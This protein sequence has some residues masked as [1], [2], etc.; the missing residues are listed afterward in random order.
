MSEARVIEQVERRFREAIQ[1]CGNE[2]PETMVADMPLIGSGVDSL[3]LARLVVQLED[4]MDYDPFMLLEEPV[5][6]RTYGEFT[7]LYRRFADRAKWAQ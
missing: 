2:A 6:P 7:E 4:D 5:Y 1:T 3:G